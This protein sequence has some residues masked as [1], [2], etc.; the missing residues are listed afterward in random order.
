[1]NDLISR[2]AVLKLIREMADDFTKKYTIDM[3]DPRELVFKVGH[4]PSVEPERKKGHWI[5]SSCDG[6]MIA[7]E[8][9]VCKRHAGYSLKWMRWYNFCPWCGA[10]LKGVEDG[11]TD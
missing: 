9:S 3:V 8:C 11:T 6:E 5:Y 1:M 2:K 7:H 10:E 4:L